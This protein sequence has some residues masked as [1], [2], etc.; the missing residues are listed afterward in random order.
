LGNYKK[1][2]LPSQNDVLAWI[3]EITNKTERWLA[4]INYSAENVSFSWAEKTKPG[5]VIFLLRHT[6]FHIGELSSLLNVSITCIVEDHW[7]KVL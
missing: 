6:V 1:D 4:N 2:D 7:V 5:V 3:H